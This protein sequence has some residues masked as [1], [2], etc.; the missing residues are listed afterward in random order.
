MRD[1]GPLQMDME[2]WHS[3]PTKVDYSVATFWYGDADNTSNAQTEEKR[4]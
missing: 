3:Q 4:K 1:F 2:V